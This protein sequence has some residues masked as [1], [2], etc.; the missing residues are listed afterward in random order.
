[1]AITI[2]WGT[3]VINVPQSYLTYVGGTNY[4]LDTNQFRIDVRTLSASEAGMANPPVLNH[5]TKVLLGGI[6][7]A[8]IIEII[9]GYTVTFEDV[10]TPYAVS[11]QGSNNNILDVTN[12]NNVAVRSNN[13]AGLVQTQELQY[14][15]FDGAITVDTVN[16]VSG[17]TYPIGSKLRPVNNI[18]DARTIAAVY[19]FGELH[20][21]GNLTLDTG[22]D[23]SDM[24]ITGDNALRTF[25]NILPGSST[26]GV[27]IR[28]CAVTGT[29]DGTTI[30][31]DCYVFD[32]TYVNGFIFQC[33][34]A[35]T[36]TLGGVNTANFLS[37]YSDIN[38]V[39]IDM[40][41]SGYSFNIASW[42]GELHIANKTGTDVAKVYSGAASIHI[43]ASVTN[44]T[45]IHLDGI[46]DVVNNSQVL[47]EVNELLS[48]DSIWSHIVDGGLSAEQL[49]RITSSVL[50]GKVS[51]A[52]TGTEVFRDLADTK[53]RVTVTVDSNGNRTAVVRD[54]S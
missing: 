49:M 52:G 44:G 26:S 35:G 7:Y 32:L 18:P 45:G 28:D 25:V 41:G 46:G 14:A 2:D 23:V 54:A 20:V 50:S 8:R 16:G 34:L 21:K 4:S 31:R 5:N 12:L 15:A 29:L 53:D 47:P 11:L 9:N 3:R 30:L 1:M 38:A 19:G 39:T 33:Q 27:E 51:G 10:G 40:N 6:E 24:R 43:D 42:K 13:S 48:V 17:T 36:I 22:D 37:C